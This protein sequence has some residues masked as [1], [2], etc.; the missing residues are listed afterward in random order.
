MLPLLKECWAR[1][2]PSTDGGLSQ[3]SKGEENPCAVLTVV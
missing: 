3:K 2:H 1:L